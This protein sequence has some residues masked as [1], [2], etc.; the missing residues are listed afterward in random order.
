MQSKTGKKLFTTEDIVDTRPEP[1][2]TGTSPQTNTY[3]PDSN[4]ETMDWTNRDRF[5]G[6]NVFLAMSSCGFQEKAR[7]NPIK[8]ILSTLHDEELNGNTF[9][10]HTPLI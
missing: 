2:V 1:A 9:R 10:D 6:L 3:R 5:R 4:T 8:E 7:T